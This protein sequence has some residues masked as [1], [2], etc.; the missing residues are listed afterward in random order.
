M[1]LAR[2]VKTG[3][4]L[5]A[6][7]E[8]LS[9]TYTGTDPREVAARI[10]LGD[11][12]NPITGGGGY[13]VQVYLNNVLVNPSTAIQIASGVTK[14]VVGS[15]PILINPGDLISL[16]VQSGMGETSVNTVASLR[17]ATPAKATDLFG[18]GTTYVDHDYGGTDNYQY[19]TPGGQPIAGA[20]VRVY[21]KSDYDANRRST[22]YIVARTTTRTD[23]RW[24]MALMLDPDNYVLLFNKPNAYGPNAV[25]LTVN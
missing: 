23:G 5:S 18:Y 25:N 1:E 22:S 17:D 4:N 12:T 21:L 10:D 8:V 15:R 7:A 13:L 6:G 16:R 14:T 9:Y 24:T 20:E 11:D 3:I 2:Q 19:V